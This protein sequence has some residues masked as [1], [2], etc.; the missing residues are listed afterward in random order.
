M[1]VVVILGLLL[2]SSAAFGEVTKE[3]IRAIVKE[4][5]TASETRMREY[6]DLKLQATNTEIKAT[7][8]K[9]EELDKRLSTKIEELDKRL[10]N[11][12]AVVIALI[13]LITAAIAVPQIIIAFKERGQSKLEAQIEQGQSKLEA[14]IEQLRQ[15]VEVL[16]QSRILRS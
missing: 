15:K 3:E 12:F 5:I 11:I 2:L 8:I 14:Q 10:G 9:I 16:E 7:N 13:A 4:E 1:K 6:I